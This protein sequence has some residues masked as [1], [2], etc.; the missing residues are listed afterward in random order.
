MARN[1]ADG[2][3]RGVP[4]VSRQGLALAN[5]MAAARQGGYGSMGMAASSMAV[6]RYGQNPNRWQGY[7]ARADSPTPSTPATLSSSPLTKE[8]VRD[9]V[10]SALSEATPPE[11]AV[12]A[13]SSKIASSTAR[14]MDYELGKLRS[15]W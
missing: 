1:I 9:A 7:G 8:D 3:T 10:A 5:A 4:L 15:R 2:M 11:I 6:R 12:Y 14:S 13:S